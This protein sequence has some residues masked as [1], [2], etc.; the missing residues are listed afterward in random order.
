MLRLHFKIENAIDLLIRWRVIG[1][2]AILCVTAYFGTQ[3]P[4]LVLDGSM[5]R[6]MLKDDPERDVWQRSVELFGSDE[7]VAVAVPYPDSVWNGDALKELGDVTASVTEVDGVIQVSSLTNSLVV[8]RMIIPRTKTTL[9]WFEGGVPVEE[10]RLAA[11]RNPTVRKNL[12]SDDGKHA[13]LTIR[14]SPRAVTTVGLKKRIVRDLRSRLDARLGAG[15]YYITG[16]P[17]VHVEIAQYMLRDL[18]V[19]VPLVACVIAILL[20]ITFRRVA[21]VLLP[22][23]TIGVAQ[24]W[25]IGGLVA[26][27]RSISMVTNSL[28]VIIVAI[29]TT[30]CVHMVSQIFRI[31]D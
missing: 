19:L 21:G 15:N 30:F 18:S 3:L 17:V 20:A 9:E 23:T 13:A 8:R 25:T 12:V 5:E 2:L 6:I 10:L 24:I 28:P 22:L 1:L 11:L 31:A 7:L 26:T 29:G 16:W 27:G 4:K 14:L